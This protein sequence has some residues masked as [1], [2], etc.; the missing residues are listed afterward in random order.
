MNFFDIIC[1][2]LKKQLTAFMRTISFTAEHKTINHIYHFQY[3][4]QLTLVDTQSI[5]SY[6]FVHILY[7]LLW[8]K[9]KNFNKLLKNL[10][11][12]RFKIKNL[13]LACLTHKKDNGKSGEYY[14]TWAWWW[15]G[16]N[17]PTPKTTLQCLAHASNA[18]LQWVTGRRGK[19]LI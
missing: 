7:F 9:S 11:L 13:F 18:A 8:L 1:E 5:L 6:D 12:L 3:W 16:G 14:S 2:I 10:F 4:S 17:Y 15:R 19:I